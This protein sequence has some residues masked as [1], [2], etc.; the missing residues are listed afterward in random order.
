MTRLRSI[1]PVAA[2]EQY[3]LNLHLVGLIAQ[4]VRR[5]MTIDDS[6]VGAIPLSETLYRIDNHSLRASGFETQRTDPGK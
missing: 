6:P 3:G 2:A 5:T 1:T 4:T